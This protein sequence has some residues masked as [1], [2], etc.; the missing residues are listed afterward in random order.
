VQTTQQLLRP[1]CLPFDWILNLSAPMLHRT[2]RKNSSEARHDFPNRRPCSV[3]RSYHCS[4]LR[5]T[6]RYVTLSKAP[7]LRPSLV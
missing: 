3:H 6:V 5:Y 7:E 2:L 1:P 4:G